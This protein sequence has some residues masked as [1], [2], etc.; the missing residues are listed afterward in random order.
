M[1]KKTYQKGNSGYRIRL[2]HGP[3]SQSVV[4]ALEEV[5]DQIVW[6]KQE[7]G[8]IENPKQGMTSLIISVLNNHDLRGKDFDRFVKEIKT[9]RYSI[10]WQ[11]IDLYLQKIDNE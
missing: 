2:H 1:N 8:L 10:D 9:R 6:R 11:Q 7:W 5:V 4:N 3:S